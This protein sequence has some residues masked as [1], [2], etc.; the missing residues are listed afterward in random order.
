MIRVND[1]ISIASGVSHIGVNGNGVG[2]FDITS[3]APFGHIF[4]LSGVFVDPILGQSGIIRY[5][6]AANAFQVSVNGG[7]TFSDVATGGT[8]VLSVGVLGDANLTGNV[9][10]A[11]P[12]SGFIVIEDT[13]DASP[14]L[15][16]VNTLALSGLWGFPTN[17]FS[18]MAKCF[19]T[20]QS[21]A[22]TWTITHNLNSTN[23][24]VS[25]YDNNSPKNE[26]IP[27]ELTITDANTVTVRFNQ[28]TAGSIT[29][30][31]C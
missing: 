22:I 3:I 13:G 11:S 24:V 7:L 12:A 19:S 15:F 10:L 14:L 26:I 16:S 6:K 30:I 28:T 2:A 4:Q 1:L 25:V 31:A 20:T 17:G 23:V 9:D 5:S 8:S 29:V 18:N 21:S 27:D